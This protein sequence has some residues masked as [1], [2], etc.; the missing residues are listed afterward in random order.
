MIS[1]LLRFYFTKLE[2]GSVTVTVIVINSEK[3]ESVTVI[4][5]FWNYE[6]GIGNP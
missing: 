6:V 3:L 4:R 5:Y 2:S 1:N